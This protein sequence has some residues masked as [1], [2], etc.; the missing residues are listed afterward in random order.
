MRR[1]FGGCA[2]HRR[3][4]HA[5]AA[6]A[7]GT[8]AAAAAAAPVVAMALAMAIKSSITVPVYGVSTHGMDLM[9]HHGGA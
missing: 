3:C 4:G 2:C 5:A 1:L 9:L 6:A 8:V 7:S